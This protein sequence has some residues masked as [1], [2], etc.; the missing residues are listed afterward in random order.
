MGG[1]KGDGGVLRLVLG[2]WVLWIQGHEVPLPLRFCD[3][4]GS[5]EHGSDAQIKGRFRFFGVLSI[6]SI[7]Y[8][9]KYT[10]I[11]IH[12]IPLNVA[13]QIHGRCQVQKI[14]FISYVLPESE[15][16]FPC[17]PLQYNYRVHTPYIRSRA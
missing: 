7:Q 4:V 8:T 10:Q 17:P 9:N 1:E 5:L 16:T 3:R 15:L 6:F 11:L 12:H 13:W 2:V 14:I